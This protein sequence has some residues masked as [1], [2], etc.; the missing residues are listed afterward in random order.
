M[1][2]LVKIVLSCP[3][4]SS[5]LMFIVHTFLSKKFNTLQEFY[6]NNIA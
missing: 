4:V 3:I 5:H 1:Y 2:L 6:E